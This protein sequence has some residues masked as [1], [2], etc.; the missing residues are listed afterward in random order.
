M[1]AKPSFVERATPTVDLPDPDT[2]MTTIDVDRSK[3]A[4]TET[5]STAWGARATCVTKP[6]GVLANDCACRGL[7]GKPRS[8]RRDCTSER[9]CHATACG[10]AAAIVLSVTLAGCGSASYSFSAGYHE[11]QALAAERAKLASV[12]RRAILS[13]CRTDWVVAGSVGMAKAPWLRGCVSGFEVV[14]QA[15]A[16]P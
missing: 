9:G 14:V 4:T 7:D 3:W 5:Y 10:A 16:R 6:A 2:P 13:A 1:N 12:P 15:V 11:G 8:Y